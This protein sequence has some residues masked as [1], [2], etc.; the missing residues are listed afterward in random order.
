MTVNPAISGRIEL[1]KTQLMAL[2][3]VM[4]FGFSA[5][6]GMP[7]N[8]DS[9]VLAF[10]TTN[11]M[12]GRIATVEMLGVAIN[13]LVFAQLSGRLNPHKTF[14]VCIIIVAAMNLGAIFAPDLMILGICRGISGLAL[15]AI[16]ATVM[17][18]AGRSDKPDM[19]FGILNACVAGMGMVLALILPQALRFYELAPG[20]GFSESD[21][22]FAVYFVLALVALIF[23]RATP[24]PNSD[25]KMDSSIPE[26]PPTPLSGWIAL[27]GLGFIFMGHGVIAM[28]FMR[29]GRTV[30]LTPE[31]IGLV[32]MAAS[33]IG[34]FMSIGAGIIGAKFK[35]MTPIGA[36]LLLLVILAPFISNPSNTVQFFLAAPLFLFLPV[37]MMPIF[38]GALSRVDPGGKLT[39]SHPA[40]VTLSGGVAP[41]LGGILADAGDG[42]TLNGWFAVACFIIGAGL[43]FSVIR[44]ADQ[45]R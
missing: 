34:I 33:G 44:A 40:F 4:L 43:M 35:S 38:L 24:R 42:F 30:E 29:I 41:I 6:L 21:G 36:I 2:I 17:S 23:I 10:S 5:A 15:G 11:A 22:L 37:G 32:G 8:L 16:I 20:Q 13:S 39:G 12:A 45:K 9:I 28:F 31:V 1:T 26:Q 27:V 3:S 18:T 7:F 25:E 19:T 14:F